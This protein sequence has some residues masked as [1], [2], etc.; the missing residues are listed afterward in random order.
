MPWVW[1]LSF[2]Y[3]LLEDN[4]FLLF[5]ILV[6]STSLLFHIFLLLPCLTIHLPLTLHNL[7]PF[8]FSL[9][10]PTSSY[11]LTCNPSIC[12]ILS[13]PGLLFYTKDGASRFLWNV[14]AY[15][16][17]YDIPKDCD[18]NEGTGYCSRVKLALTI[19]NDG[20]AIF[21]IMVYSFIILRVL[22]VEFIT[23]YTFII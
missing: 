12:I 14:A 9:C 7:F 23:F 20:F 16:P 10:R 8:M 4:C 18:L 22:S 6:S 2:D 15:L 3:S 17:K 5:P 13:P 11:W 19:W 21:R 1:L